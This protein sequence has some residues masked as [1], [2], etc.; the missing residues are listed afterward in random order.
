MARKILIGIAA[1]IVIL[2]LVIA[3]RPDSFHIERSVTVSAPPQIPFVAVNDFHEWA[4]WTPYEKL[5]PQMKKT[6]EGPT[7]GVGAVYKWDGNDKSGA[8]SMT[9]VT[10]EAPSRIVLN[11]DFT[12]PFTASNVATFTFTPVGAG[13]KVT[14]AMD[15]HSGFL[16]KAFGLVMNMDSLVGNDFAS[17]LETLKTISEAKATSAAPQTGMAR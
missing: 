6:F 11:L 3:T 9:N 1:V 13:T 17:G 7:A 16:S 12:K 2:V 8:G 4:A 5:D 15:G 10:T 14:W